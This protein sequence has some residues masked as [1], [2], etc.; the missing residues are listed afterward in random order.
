MDYGRLIIWSFLFVYY[1]NKYRKNKELKNLVL[2]SIGLYGLTSLKFIL[3][4]Y[5]TEYIKHIVILNILQIIS[6][7][8]CTCIII[9]LYKL[10]KKEKNA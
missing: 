6:L 9:L 7:I 8:L 3:V 5:E 10:H 1:G 4:N 2:S